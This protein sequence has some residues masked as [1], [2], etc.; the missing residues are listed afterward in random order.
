MD[1][2][3]DLCD[4][5][6]DIKWKCIE[7][8]EWLCHRCKSIHS[9]SRASRGHKIASLMETDFHSLQKIGRY[10][11]E[12]QKE[13]YQMYCKNCDSLL[14]LTCVTEKHKTHEFVTLFHI[15][16]VKKAEIDECLEKLKTMYLTELE[17]SL[18]L[19]KHTRSEHSERVSMSVYDVK[20]QNQE[21]KKEVDSTKSSIIREIDQKASES[22]EKMSQMEDQ[23]AKRVSLIQKRIKRC[24]ERRKNQSPFN[25]IKLAAEMKE[26]VERYQDFSPTWDITI[27]KFVPGEILS[28]DIQNLYGKTVNEYVDNRT[29][30]AKHKRSAGLHTNIK[31]LS[32]FNSF[33][34]SYSI[35]TDSKAACMWIGR[36]QYLAQ[37]D[38]NGRRKKWVNLDFDL[39][40]IATTISGNLLV[41]SSNKIY[42]VLK[43]GFSAEFVT[44]ELWFITDI[45]VSE[46]DEI[47]VCLRDIYIGKSG[48]VVRLSERGKQLQ[49]IQYD[50][51]GRVLFKWPEYLTKAQN[52]D[53]WVSDTKDNCVVV[54]SAEGDL[55]FRYFG[56]EDILMNQ[57][58]QPRG[59]L[60]NRYNQILIAD[61]NNHAIHLVDNDGHFLQFL[62]TKHHRIDCPVALCQDNDETLWVV[63][64]DG[65]IVNVRYLQ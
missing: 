53:I 47:L 51:D 13:L 46:D 60:T 31:V 56:F 14:C 42:K 7:C 9:K 58:F 22:T 37:L 29:Q 54:S 5:D 6:V 55:K 52:G 39:Y 16:E 44:F 19:L 26:A 48:K 4:D 36:D 43:E 34:R 45:L 18:T 10:C 2:K 62:L 33:V 1:V 17:N 3:C 32:E 24:E 63:C 15:V 65:K 38:L 57:K 61:I 64:N 41:G 23:M 20:K 59:L 40:C 21:I 27:P 49:T 8:N 11:I 35:V 25:L 50:K 28:S 12:H 30:K